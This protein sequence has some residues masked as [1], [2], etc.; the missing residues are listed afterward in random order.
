MLS[1]ADRLTPPSSGSS[2]PAGWSLGE[3]NV[4]EFVDRS[5]V[6]NCQLKVGDRIVW[7]S[8]SGPEF[9]DVMWVG[10]LPDD[11]GPRVCDKL[12]AGV[13]F[14]NPIGSGTGTYHSHVLFKARNGHASLIP[15][16]GL[17]KTED[18]C[19]GHVR[20]CETTV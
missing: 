20:V 17:M 14:D 7:M 13:Q 10:F 9:G 11:V 16:G 18:L 15:I 19:S 2:L 8:D 4:T 3:P 6:E 1:A 12:I 5:L